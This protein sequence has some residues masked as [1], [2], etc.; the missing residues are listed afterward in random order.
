MILGD[1]AGFLNSQRL[2]GIHLA[3]KSG[4]LAGETAFEALKKDDLSA[5]TLGQFQTRVENSWIKDELWKVRNFH[6]GFEH[7][8]LPGMFHAGIAAVHRRTRHAQSLSCDAG[9]QRMKKLR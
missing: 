1:S 2:K 8:F 3:I 9:L 4:M 5:A 6:Q 7:G